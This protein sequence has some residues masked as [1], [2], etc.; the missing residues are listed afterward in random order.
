MHCFVDVLS[1]LIILQISWQQ[2]RF[3]KNSQYSYIFVRSVILKTTI[4]IK[5]TVL[6]GE[7]KYTVGENNMTLTILDSFS[8]VVKTEYTGILVW[9]QLAFM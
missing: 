1:Q 3:L 7:C 6:S 5:H 4:A 9:N 2:Y 8:D